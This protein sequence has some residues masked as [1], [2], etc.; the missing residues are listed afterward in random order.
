[1]NIVTLI[2]HDTGRFLPSYGVETLRMPAVDRLAQEGLVLDN[3]FCNAPQCCPSRAVLFT[4]LANYRTGIT[5]MVNPAEGWTFQPERPHI[6]QRLSDAGYHT[7]GIGILHEIGNT[8]RDPDALF[9]AQ[10]FQDLIPRMGDEDRFGPK[11][12]ERFGKW[13]ERHDA[14]RPKQPFY[15]QIGIFESHRDY[16]SFGECGED[17]SLGVTIP[18]PLKD[19]PATRKDFAELQA[20]MRLVDET[21]G[22]ILDTLDRTGHAED[23]LFIF[24]TDH[25]LEVPRGKGTLYG[26]GMETLFLMRGP[27]IPQGERYPHLHS[28]CDLVPTLLEALGQAPDPEL[29]GVSHWQALQQPAGSKAPRDAHFGAKTQHSQYDPM[30]SIRTDDYSYIF[31]FD[32]GR[33]ENCCIEVNHGPLHTEQL[34]ILNVG[35]KPPEELYDLRSDP[36]ELKNLAEDPD[37]AGIKAE[38]Q[39]RLARHLVRTR[40]PLLDGPVEAPRTRERRLALKEIGSRS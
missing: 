17:S 30:R 11:H 5:G 22:S 18:P 2:T 1:M 6:A 21:V 10:G 37:Y 15:A 35:R 3:A 19:G 13:L 23:T 38:L 31:N 8:G 28:H 34:E 16:T 4:G 39:Q 33:P 20:M 7:L 12:A 27:G 25:G 36:H 29:D 32:A 24:T 14:E 9:K 26:L 40:D